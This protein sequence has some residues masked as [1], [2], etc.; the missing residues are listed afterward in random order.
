MRKSLLVWLGLLISSA[1]N[2]SS[3]LARLDMGSDEIRAARRTTRAD[4]LV[5]QYRREVWA[6]GGSPL[7][8]VGSDTLTADYVAVTAG[9]RQVL[10]DFALCRSLSLR[11][12][13]PAFANGSCFAGPAFRSAELVNRRMLQV[14]LDAAAKDTAAKTRTPLATYWAEQELAAQETVSDPLSATRTAWNTDWR[15]GTEI[16]V[17]TSGGFSFSNTERKAVARFLAR[18]L[19]LHPH[20][21]TTETS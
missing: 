19:D 6:P 5:F 2:A 13:E 21:I 8:E 10:E 15:L 20:L 14:M 11:N 1:V 4:A 7:L 18:S 3:P 9:D 12:G 17:R 16:V